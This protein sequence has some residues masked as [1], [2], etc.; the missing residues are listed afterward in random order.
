[1]SLLMFAAIGLAPISYAVAGAVAQV[2]LQAMF[3]AA[4]ALML[5]V[6]GIGLLNGAARSID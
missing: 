1:M 3:L 5:L 6:A 4:G 2:Y